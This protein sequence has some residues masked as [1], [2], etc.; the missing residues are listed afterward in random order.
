[1]SKSPC[2]TRKY[3][4]IRENGTRFLVASGED[5]FV[6]DV[7][8]LIG[9]NE[10]YWIVDKTGEAGRIAARFDPRSRSL[11]LKT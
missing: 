3:E 7:E 1:L 11:P 8:S 6:P 9:Q 5:H 10:R 4:A 2:P